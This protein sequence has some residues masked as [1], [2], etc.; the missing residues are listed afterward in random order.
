MTTIID[1]AQLA[2]LKQA[3]YVMESLFR[4]DSKEQIVKV[5]D[6]DEQLYN[7]WKLFLKNNN[8]ITETMEGWAVTG[9]GAMWNRRVRYR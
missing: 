6:G 9:K 7:M 5:L 2:G 3:M 8:G 4:N 1:P